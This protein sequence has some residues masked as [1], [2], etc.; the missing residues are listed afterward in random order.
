MTIDPKPLI[1]HLSR[2]PLRR[3][4][5]KAVALK[6]RFEAVATEEEGDPGAW[7]A[8]LEGQDPLPEQIVLPN[9]RRLILTLRFLGKRETKWAGKPPARVECSLTAKHLVLKRIGGN[10]TCYLKRADPEPLT[11]RIA[12]TA[13]A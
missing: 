8:P 10:G 6:G 9:L 5:I 7:L 1:E 12:G 3:G 4:E 2:I 13:S 11:T